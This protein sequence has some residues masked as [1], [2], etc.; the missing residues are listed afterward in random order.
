MYIVRRRVADAVYLYQVPVLYYV[1]AIIDE[2]RRGRT[3]VCAIVLQRS[4]F[5]NT[6]QVPNKVA[7]SE[8]SGRH[9]PSEK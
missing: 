9:K 2:E 5:A 3:G 6:E 8:R 1:V 4:V 7:F